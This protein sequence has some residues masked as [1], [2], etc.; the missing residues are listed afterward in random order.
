MSESGRLRALIDRARLSRELAPFGRSDARKGIWQL[1]NTIIPYVGL[2]A[3]MVVGRLQGWHWALTLLLALPAAALL[4]RIF[5]FFHDCCHDSFF[6]SRAANRVTGWVTGI[7]TFT[8]FDDWK[9]SHQRHHTTA[10]DL[11]NRGTGD[12]WTMTVDEYLA[13]S[14]RK[15]LGYRL[16]RN[17]FFLLLVVPFYLSLIAYRI[18]RRGAG[19][20]AA[21]SVLLTDLALLAIAVIAS[22]TIGLGNY[23]L[24]QLPVI[25]IS[26]TSGVWLFYVQH[27]FEGTHWSRHEEWE[28][29]E[30]ALAGS[31]YYKLPR[32][33]QWFTGN[34]GLHHIHHLRP[35]IPNYHLQACQDA[36]PAL[37]LIRPLTLRRSLR[38]V[39]MN[40]WDEQ[41]QKL[42]SFRAIRGRPRRRSWRT[43]SPAR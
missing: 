20:A 4:I 31:S 22:R 34:I 13:A 10:G 24:V 12:V 3:L 27:Q 9:Q 19:R 28:P 32:V 7:L 40:L 26:W 43:A 25:V 16:V 15:R 14:R 41:Q 21:A 39:A 5:I 6:G 8:P 38:S 29:I 11:D 33:L 36:V 2:L 42:V 17:P 23:L 30:A 1:A 37:Q 35:R 18:P